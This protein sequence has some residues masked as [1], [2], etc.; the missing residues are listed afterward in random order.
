LDLV[1]T[2]NLAR[3]QLTT[4]EKALVAEQIAVAQRGG[5]QNG[6]F[7]VTQAAQQLRVSK[8]NI[9]RVRK[10]KE[11][12]PNVYA[13]LLRKEYKNL[14][15]AY[16]A[17]GLNKPPAKAVKTVFLVA[18]SEETDQ[19]NQWIVR[20]ALNAADKESVAEHNRFSREDQ[21]ERFA[22]QLNEKAEAQRQAE[23]QADCNEVA[24]EVVTSIKEDSV[25]PEPTQSEPAESEPVQSEPTSTAAAADGE[26]VDLTTLPRPQ[27]V[28]L[29]N[30]AT[31]PEDAPEPNA[32]SMGIL[33]K[34]LRDSDATYSDEG[35]AWFNQY[36][37]RFKE[38]EALLQYA[39]GA[40]KKP[41]M[42][43]RIVYWVKLMSVKFT[44]RLLNNRQAWLKSMLNLSYA[45]K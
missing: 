16:N 2:E 36:G 15:A 26:M 32:G 24:K 11:Q 22:I 17:A 31:F 37:E 35:Y 25:Q 13:A 5:K 39:A 44:F 10:L 38:M 14:D 19:W 18:R 1:I 7:T 3:R 30:R 43:D 40:K 29:A 28:D 45:G 21:A 42:D 34:S 27:L 12:A 9:G 4:T 20:A 8:S 33:L 6:A 41:L 23:E